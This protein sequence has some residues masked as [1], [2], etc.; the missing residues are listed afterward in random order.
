[1]KDFSEKI[2]R[3]PHHPGVYLMKDENDKI[4]YVG[5]AKNLKNR[6]S[7]YFTG[8]E[9]LNRKTQRL[10]VQIQDFEY[11]ITNSELEALI[12][13]A[14]LI[15][16][17]MPH[18]NI[19]LKDD[20]SFPYLKLTK[21]EYPRLIKTRQV[22]KDGAEYFGPYTSG[23]VLNKQIELVKRLF[24]LRKCNLSMDKKHKK[25]CLYKH[26][27]M[28]LAPCVDKT[29][30][31]VYAEEVGSLSAFLKKGSGDLKHILEEE[32]RDA[33]MR[34]N[35]ERAAILRDEIAALSKLRETQVIKNLPYEEADVIALARENDSAMIVVLYIRNSTIIDR[36]KIL[37]QGVE[38]ES[39]EEILR[40]FVL[41]YYENSSYIPKNLDLMLEMENMKLLED[42]LNSKRGGGVRLSSPKR[43]HRKKLVNIAY[44]NAKELLQRELKEELEKKKEKDELLLKLAE[45]LGLPEKPYRIEMYDIS[46]TL[47]SYS[48]GAMVVYEDGLKKKNDYRKFKI[49]TVGG[50]DDY[51][52]MMEMLYRRLRRGVSDDDLEN[53]GFDSLPDL[54]LIDG[55]K[56]HVSAVKDVIRALDLNLRVA[57]LVKDDK[58]TTRAIYYEGNEF[59]IDRHSRLYPFLASIQEEVHRF[60]IDYHRSLRDKGLIKSELDD[61]K[62][63]GE[64]RKKALL[65]KFGS[66][67]AIKN[68]GYDE[69]VQTEN[70]TKAVAENILKY[71]SERTEYK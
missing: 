63:V 57:G 70:M 58:H 26:M 6:V 25:P 50:V 35:Y 40:Q 47:G 61:I 37:M 38:D 52:S 67:D 45:I 3:L 12:L 32:M 55:G 17:H 34:Q 44:L 27:G 56:A 42:Y 19:L 43:A 11:I 49:K 69:L 28:C 53:R 46:N 29:V 9:S 24:K 2:S 8:F 13:E 59:V 41:Q 39:C 4:I 48:V 5:K 15:K 14:E 65:Q 10:V 68:A 20:K 16:K 22:K 66:V 7:S 51:H 64:A 62:G 33:A 21:E 18:F 54:I 31:E 30:A 60:A 71:Y 36:E 23:L 1:M